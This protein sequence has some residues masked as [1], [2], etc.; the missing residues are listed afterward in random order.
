MNQIKRNFFIHICVVILVFFLFHFS[1]EEEEERK[2]RK[3]ER[4]ER[5]LINSGRRIEREGRRE[6]KGE[7]SINL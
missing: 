6:W 2:E 1:E 5:E 3:R 4:I 7:I